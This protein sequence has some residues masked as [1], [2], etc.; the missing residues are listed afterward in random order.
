[1]GQQFLGHKGLGWEAGVFV[2]RGFR[3]V[4][5]NKA[6]CVVFNFS[7]VKSSLTQSELHPVKSTAHCVKIKGILVILHKNNRATEWDYSVSDP[8]G[9]F[10]QPFNFVKKLSEIKMGFSH[11]LINWLIRRNQG[12]NRDITYNIKWLD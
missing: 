11:L 1:M 4:R 5:R 8:F 7:A 6:L 10:W 3:L 12:F 2:R 9:E